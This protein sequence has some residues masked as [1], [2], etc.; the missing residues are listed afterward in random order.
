MESE[1]EAGRISASLPDSLVS[2]ICACLLA[3]VNMTLIWKVSHEIYTTLINK[4]IFADCLVA[5]LNIPLILHG[6]NTIKLSCSFI[7]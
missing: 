3:A 6:E 2:L 5:L 7:T 4:L 1:S